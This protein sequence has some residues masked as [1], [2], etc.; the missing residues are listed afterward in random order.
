[1]F[2]LAEILLIPLQTHSITPLTWS[3]QPEFDLPLTVLRN[4]RKKNVKL[5]LL[6]DKA[7]YVQIHSAPSQISPVADRGLKVAG[8]WFQIA[9][10]T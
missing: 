8:H 9:G 2:A 4:R 7:Y 3:H 6:Y 5:D 1:M 10:R